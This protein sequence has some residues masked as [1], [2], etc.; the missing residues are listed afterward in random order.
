MHPV[1]SIAPAT[2]PT[3]GSTPQLNPEQEGMADAQLA[4]TVFQTPMPAFA[5][6]TP[7]CE[8]ELM[9]PVQVLTD[10]PHAPLGPAQSTLAQAGV[11]HAGASQA[12]REHCAYASDG[13]KKAKATTRTAYA[14]R[15]SGYSLRI[16]LPSPVPHSCP[17]WAARVAGYK[18]L[19]APWLSQ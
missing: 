12:P 2:S 18:S 11:S 3:C 17:S 19:T 7:A 14:V 15:T 9:P 13:A 10:D 4:T 5:H 8:Q 16:T 1:S 6:P